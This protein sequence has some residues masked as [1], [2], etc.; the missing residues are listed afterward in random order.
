MSY[1]VA[2][3]FTSINGEG[4]RAGEAAVFIRFRGCDLCCSYCDTRWACSDSAPAQIMTAEQ[5]CGYAD[6]TGIKNVTLTGGEPLLQE[7]LYLLTDMLAAHG[8]TAE[9]ETN[10]ASDISFLAERAARPF[11]T[12]DYKLPGSGMEQHML[13]D[14][15]R[16]LIKGDAVKFVS[17]SE[18]D[19]ERCAQITERYALTEK[20][21]VFISPVF[22]RIDPQKIVSFI[23]ERK[24]VGV[25]LQLQL[26]KYIWDPEKRGV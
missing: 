26:H 19:L 9:I 23:L 3:L 4:P 15:Y 18:E 16:Y 11:F 8:H 24:L 7:E 21:A 14:N 1:P 12:L 13:T 17:G 20:C 25:R 6:G 22:G 2:E 5:L 10:G